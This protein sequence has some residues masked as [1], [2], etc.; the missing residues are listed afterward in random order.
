M[1]HAIILAAGK[2]ERFGKKDK[3]LV[4]ISGKPLIYYTLMAFN[5][6]PEVSTVTLVVN[7]QNSAKIKE[8][9]R[10]YRFPKVKKYVFGAKTR[11]ESVKN[12]L[13]SLKIKAEEV[14]LVHNGANPLPSQAEIS[15]CLK[16]AKKVGACIVGHFITSTIKEVKVSHVLKTHDRN[17]L[18]AAETPQCAKFGVLRAALKKAADCTDEAMALEEVGQKIAFVKAGENNFKI[19]TEKDLIHLKSILGETPED[20]LVG[21]GQ[22]SHEFDTVKGLTLAGLRLPQELKLKA[23]SDGDVI[24]HAIFNAISQAI[25]EKSLGFYADKKFEKGITDS[26]KY[27]EPLLKKLVR[28]NLKINSLGLML[29]CKA[30]KIDPIN[31]KIKKSLS[32]ILSLSQEKIGITATSGEGLTVFGQGRGIQCF[33]IISLTKQQKASK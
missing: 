11:Q 29:E 33:A 4:E 7:R 5:D 31:S 23:N 15:E 20:F 8:I 14:V 9:V 17:K 18:F 22:D 24:L 27:L 1:S 25:G 12:G 32:E 19:T 30:P 28:K 16:K 21:I 3:L 6:H 10:K 13:N 2:S 26:R